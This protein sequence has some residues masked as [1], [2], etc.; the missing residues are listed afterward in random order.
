MPP[1]AKDPKGG[2]AK[3]GKDTA[4]EE[5]VLHVR[6]FL[7]SYSSHSGAAGLEMLHLPFSPVTT[8]G[9]GPFGRVVVHPQLDSGPVPTAG[10][11]KVLLEALAASNYS[12]LLT[13]ALWNVPLG[14]LGATCVAGFMSQNRTV[15]NCELPDCGLGT[16]ACKSLCEAL[17]K[18]RTLTRLNL[19]HNKLGDEGLQALTENIHANQTLKQL[20]LAF[21]ELSGASAGRI[22]GSILRIGTLERLELKGNSLGSAGAAFIFQRLSMGHISM[23]HIGVADTSFGLEPDVHTALNACMRANKTLISYD[24]RGNHIGDS[25]AYG[26]AKMLTMEAKHVI[27]LRLSD[28]IDPP[29]FKQVLNAAAV[30]KKEW[31]KMN[32]KKKG[33]KG[34][35]KGGKKK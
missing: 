10:H 21:C 34:G 2:K 16:G 12:H 31:V 11:V 17:E 27:D 1:K 9:T 29:L 33:K 15:I 35:K 25:Y 20:S 4:G 14:D 22:T 28:R 5:A 8:E 26:Y 18:N 24:L 23:A 32:K 6:A 3:K 7:K 19:D 13:L 30:N